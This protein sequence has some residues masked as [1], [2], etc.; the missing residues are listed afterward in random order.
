MEIQ[1]TS[2]LNLDEGL[3]L[4]HEQNVDLTCLLSPCQSY[5]EK[6]GKTKT[7]TVVRSEYQFSSSVFDLLEKI[8]KCMA[9]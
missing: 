7:K 8:C 9:Y 1:G 2:R 5:E 3:F 4:I 6:G